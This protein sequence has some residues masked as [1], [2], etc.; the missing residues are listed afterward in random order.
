MEEIFGEIEDEH[1]KNDLIEQKISD[2]EYI[3]S[4]R[5]E[6]D[7]LNDKYELYLPNEDEYETIAGLILHCKEDIPKLNEELVIGEY[8]K[9]KI[10]E[11]SNTRIERVQL[12]IEK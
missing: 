8:F 2:T 9:F 10:L 1:D 5:Q 7:Y 3:L 6:I 11:V 12:F 4:G